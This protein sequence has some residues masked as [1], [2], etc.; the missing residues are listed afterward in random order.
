MQIDIQ[1]NYSFQ[2]QILIKSVAVIGAKYEH[3]CW[4]T[5]G[6]E[7]GD[8]CNFSPRPERCARDVLLC[9]TEVICS[10]ESTVCVWWMEV[11]SADSYRRASYIT[12]SMQ[13]PKMLQ[14]Q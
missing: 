12:A 5:S 2:Q 13:L 10:F 7:I 6:F 9:C 3:I 11:V 1:V 4:Q 14:N 8:T